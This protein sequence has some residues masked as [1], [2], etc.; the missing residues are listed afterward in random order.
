MMSVPISATPLCCLWRALQAI[1]RTSNN[2]QGKHI[3]SKQRMERPVTLPLAAM[4]SVIQ[5]A[6][7]DGWLFYDF[8]RSNPIAHRI[9]QLDPQAMFTRRW[10]YYVPATGMPTALVSAVESHVL[11]ELPGD[12]FVFQTWQDLT[13][14]LRAMLGG[15]HRVAMEY[16]PGNAIPVCSKVDAGTVELVRECGTTE[17]PV[18]PRDPPFEVVTSADLA[19]RFE[20]VLTQAQ[21]ESHRQAAHRLLTAKDQLL[22]WIR[23]SLIA[24]GDGGTGAPE[25]VETQVQARFQAFIRAQGLTG[26]HAPIVAVN[27]HAGDPH[28]EP[29]IAQDVPLR[30]GDL[31][32]L[33]FVG[34]M[35]DDPLS[36]IADYTWMIAL[37]DHV[38]DEAARLFA[39]I[40]HARDIGIDFIRKRFATGQSV[41]G[42]EV[43]DAVRAVV[44]EAGF[45]AQFV[46]RSGH[47]ITTETH[48]SGCNLDNLE[49]H[50]DRL[51]LPGTVCSME[52]GIYLPHI[53]VRTEVN[54]LIPLASDGGSNDMAEGVE[55]EVT[56][57]PAQQ[58]ILPLL[59]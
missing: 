12:R 49:T 38:P 25:L 32:L 50:D 4:Q 30:R 17:G 59:A 44:R 26:E 37:D 35:A 21:L 45:G 3:T 55:I 13:R 5:Q 52:P 8:R 16:S 41:H 54:V 11:R 29:N 20:A 27:A 9:L 48:G 34:R 10:F 1:V 42:Y 36:V 6:G 7:L 58:A 18:G 23:E 28:F 19:Q 2:R 57:V 51:L 43:D 47:S 56:G 15:A 22:Q 40:T 53:G 39:I 31:L 33:D 24:V 14:L 46:H